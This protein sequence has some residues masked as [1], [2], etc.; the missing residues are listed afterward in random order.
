MHL[1]LPL[2]LLLAP[3][4]ALAQDVGSTMYAV[5]NTPTVRFEGDEVKGPK[6][7]EGDAV[8]VLYVDGDQVR[9]RTDSDRY[10]WLPASDLTA[11]N[12]HPEA[13]KP[14][15]APGKKFSLEELKQLLKNTKPQ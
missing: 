7:V 6:L 15:A 4:P 14:A 9:V 1:L 2:V 11:T 8:T 5:K 12:P 13:A 10:G 3:L